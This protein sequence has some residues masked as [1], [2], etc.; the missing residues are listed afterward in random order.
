[1]KQVRSTDRNLWKY[2]YKRVNAVGQMFSSNPFLVS[3]PENAA[4]FGTIGKNLEIVN[5]CHII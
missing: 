2:M 1:V 4:Y 3:G 5:R